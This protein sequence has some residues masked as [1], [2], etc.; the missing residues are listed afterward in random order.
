L[1]APGLA[2]IAA[3]SRPVHYRSN[4]SERGA[5]TWA[6]RARGG[7][8]ALGIGGSFR[9]DRG[10]HAGQVTRVDAVTGM[11]TLRASGRRFETRE[12][13]HAWGVDVR[14]TWR[15]VGVAAEY[16]RGRNRA[17]ALTA[18]DFTVVAT[19]VDTSASQGVATSDHTR[20]DLSRAD[21]SILR[22]RR[23]RPKS[24][25]MELETWWKLRPNAADRVAPELRFEF[26]RHAFEP[27]VTG[28]GFRMRRFGIGAQW[29]TR[30]A[31]TWIEA[32]LEH[33]TFDY[34][35]GATWETQFWLRRHVFWLDRDVA[36]V[37][38]LPLLGTD[39]AATVRLR[40]A[41]GF[42]RDVRAEFAT[43]L[44]APG[45]DRAP[46]FSENILRASIPIS[47][48]WSVQTH[49]RLATYR[50]FTSNDAA[51]LAALGGPGP[52]FAIGAGVPA[53]AATGYRS[54]AAHFVELVWRLS[55]R[56]DLGFGFGVDP[57]VVDD[58]INEYADVGWDE[59]LFT[60]GVAP[61]A[62]VQHP[63]D[64]GP[65]VQAAEAALERE[66]RIGVEARVRF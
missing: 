34:P 9:W 60:H 53:G 52:H 31:D 54:H 19:A 8:D 64:L 48:A 40:A 16:L 13:S 17:R 6:F 27:L 46:R 55:P 35:A 10:A 32:D 65:R 66:R 21:R 14:G 11:D 4:D 63:I 61:A 49:S 7:T 28:T 20:F 3:R 15:G 41:R 2:A 36:G 57:I 30:I 24:P 29:G 18:S 37:A 5:D 23:A 42:A 1:S 25:N 38:R 59:F 58:V 45:F 51:T 26:E 56:A 33:D 43:T 50:T 12:E 44:A 62:V 39:R 47:R 22:L